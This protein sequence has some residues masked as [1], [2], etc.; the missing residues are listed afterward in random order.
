MLQPILQIVLTAIAI[1]FTTL[2]VPGVNLV[3]P[4]TIWHLLLIGLIFGVLNSVIKPIVVMLSLPLL[5]VTLGLFYF[6]INALILW[7]TGAIFDTFVVDGFWAAL[8]G[9]I[10]ITIIN[11]ALSIFFGVKNAEYHRI[12]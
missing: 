5:V 4:W 11:W 6:V 10:I 2:I 9:S 1:Y 3:E 12:H 7:L 8:L